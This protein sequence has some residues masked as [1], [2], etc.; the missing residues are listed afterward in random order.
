MVFDFPFVV[1][2]PESAAR[3]GYDA[4]VHEIFAGT[5]E[6]HQASPSSLPNEEAN[7]G[8][9]EMPGHG[10]TTRACIFI[11]D[12][13]FRPADEANGSAHV[14]AVARGAIVHQRAAQIIQNVVGVRPAAV[15]TLINHRSLLSRLGEEVTIEECVST[16][17]SVGQIDISQFSSAELLHFSAV[18]LHPRQL[19]ES[20]FTLDGN[21]RHFA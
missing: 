14:F 16:R 3:R 15:E 17:G 10:V 11:D 7:L 12:H 21:D 20:P 4:S 6:S 9:A 8:L 19:S 1:R 18:V 5:E 2:R 13:H